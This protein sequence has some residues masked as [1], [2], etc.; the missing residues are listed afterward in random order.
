MA[1]I[2]KAIGGNLGNLGNPLLLY[3]ERQSTLE[4]LL[5]VNLKAFT[6]LICQVDQEE[7]KALN[8]ERRYLISACYTTAMAALAYYRKTL[9]PTV[10]AEGLTHII[11]TLTIEPLEEDENG[12]K[13]ITYSM[14]LKAAL[15]KSEHKEL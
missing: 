11:D 10:F 5:D 3:A 12:L 9:N 2:T 4:E 14:L 15:A 6:Y 7:E 8:I 13:P 1:R